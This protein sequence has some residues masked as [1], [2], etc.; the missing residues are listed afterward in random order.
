MSMPM[1]LCIW[2]KHTGVLIQRL[3][4]LRCILCDVFVYIVVVPNMHWTSQWLIQATQKEHSVD[5]VSVVF[6]QQIEKEDE[7]VRWRTTSKTKRRWRGSHRTLG[8]AKK[9]RC[10]V[11]FSLS[12]SRY[13]ANNLN[14]HKICI[15]PV[16]VQRRTYEP[17]RSFSSIFDMLLCF[18]RCRCCRRCFVWV[19]SA[20]GVFGKRVRCV[21]G[22]RL[23]PLPLADRN[24]H[25]TYCTSL[26]SLILCLFRNIYTKSLSTNNMIRNN[27]NLLNTF[28]SQQHVATKW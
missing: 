26:F 1:Y 16:G 10:V 7:E 22:L 27:T 23:P 14:E 20:F 2:N 19:L 4:C 8:R 15:L 28:F 13:V 18:R 21:Y 11:S 12:L 25:K 17:K 24:F 5:A 9:S 6:A 3:S